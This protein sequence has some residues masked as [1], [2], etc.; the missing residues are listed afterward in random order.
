MK[1][2][3]LVSADEAVQ[4]KGQHT[5][6]CGDCPWAR[7]SLPGWL[8]GSPADDW[9]KEVHGD[10]VI[11]CHTLRGAQCAGAAIYRRN[12]VKTPRDPECLRLEANRDLVFATPQ[13]FKAHHE[14]RTTPAEQATGDCQMPKQEVIAMNLKLKSVKSAAADALKATKEKHAKA[15]DAVKESASKKVVA[16]ETRAKK[17]LDTVVSTIDKMDAV[18]EA[19][20]KLAGTPTQKPEQVLAKIRGMA[21]KIQKLASKYL[22]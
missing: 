10:N 15:I 1:R 7:A 21:D 8:G 22:V 11:P 20:F 14:S 6:P 16:A 17:K 12:V 3:Q 5:K 13:E 2:L 9:L 18:A 4:A 19:I